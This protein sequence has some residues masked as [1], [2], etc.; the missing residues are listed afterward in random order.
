MFDTL[1]R[2]GN[3][4]L[5]G[6]GVV[7]G[8]V[9]IRDGKIAAV[10]DGLDPAGAAEVIDAEGKYVFPGAIETHSHLGLAKGAA[11]FDTETSA[12][13]L[14]GV[15]TNLFFLRQPFPYEELYDTIRRDA[16]ER[17]YTDYALHLVLISEEHLN[18]IP[19]YVEE[20]GI[21]S[22]K[23]YLTYRGEQA[24]TGLYGGTMQTFG[25]LDN[26]YMLDCFRAIARY[27]KAMAIV[28]AE[29]I[30]IIARVTKKIKDSGRD[31]MAA[32]S[33]SRPTF[34]EAEGVRRAISFAKEAGC[35]VNIL[36]LTSERALEAFYEQKRTY[37]KCYLE[38]CQPYLMLDQTDITSNEFKVRPP[39]RRPEDREALWRALLRGDV[40]S[41]GS[42]HVPRLAE[43]KTG[44]VWKQA[45]GVPGTQYLFYNMLDEA[46]FRRGLP[47]ETLAEQISLRPAKLYGLYP[48][49]GDVS[50]GCDADLLIV[51][52]G[53]STTL[54]KDSFP[55]YSD[56]N[57]YEGKEIPAFIERTLVR[58]RTVALEG[59][60][61]GLR[62][63]EY[64]A[65][66]GK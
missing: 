59:K 58:G 53:R 54:R 40:N 12:A 43:E 31:D 41:V 32:Y 28:H 42:D 38:V 36:H 30:E 22:F 2:Q 20:M 39:L 10:A 62:G 19:K 1:I 49:K 5:P 14:G 13:V 50:V 55:S 45:A 9:G 15:T 26:G 46:H 47:L 65:R 24:K 8:D 27:P 33:E 64:I 44:S 21:T 37:D 52:F 60:L 25:S 17:S 66:K 6:R 48:K 57:V 51:D 61:T 4:V 7:K 23:F 18:S 16:A 35:R 34:A 29:D 56:Y 63:G 3:I 11:D